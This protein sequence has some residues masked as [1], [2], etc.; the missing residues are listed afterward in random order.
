MWRIGP[1]A[2]GTD[3]PARSP[4]VTSNE[5]GW[6]VVRNEARWCTAG[7]T[8]DVKYRREPRVLANRETAPIAILFRPN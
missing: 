5:R 3:R 8:T 6:M 2:I 1:A 4:V 7:A